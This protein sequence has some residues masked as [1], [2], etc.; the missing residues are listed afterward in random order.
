MGVRLPVPRPRR[1]PSPSSPR[2]NPHDPVPTLVHCVL[3]FRGPLLWYRYRSTRGLRRIHGMT[4][5]TSLHGW[6][7]ETLKFC[8]SDLGRNEPSINWTISTGSGRG[9]GVSVCLRPRLQPQ[10]HGNNHLPLHTQPRVTG[11]QPCRSQ[12][13]RRPRF[14]D[15]VGCGPRSGLVVRGKSGTR[16]G[17]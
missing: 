4:L 2:Q 10:S 3:W 17:R 8:L 1:F 14:R 15:P 5:R 13:F 16:P 12:G 11:I 7:V 6:G 9:R